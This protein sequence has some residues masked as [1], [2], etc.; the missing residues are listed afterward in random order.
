MKR[1]FEIETAAAMI[2]RFDVIFITSN[3]PFFWSV[4]RLPTSV[5]EIEQLFVVLSELSLFFPFL[6]CSLLLLLDTDTRYRRLSP[7]PQR[8]ILSLS[9]ES[10][11]WRNAIVTPLLTAPSCFLPPTTNGLGASCSL[12]SRHPLPA[13]VVIISA[14]MS[15]AW[16]NA[17]SNNFH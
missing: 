6:C 4:C 16:W 15:S 9:R 7:R 1:Q 5:L 2:T 17:N 13:A 14:I 11:S 12:V 10:E 8:T 3:F